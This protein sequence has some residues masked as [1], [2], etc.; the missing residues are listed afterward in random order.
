MPEDKVD[1]Q[2]NEAAALLREITA[3][4][5]DQDKREIERQRLELEDSKKTPPPKKWWA[6]AI[7]IL[8]LPAAVIAIVV[9]LTNASSTVQTT[10][11]TQAETEK[12]KVEEM[13]TRVELQKMLDE[14][15]ETKKKGVT[16]YRDEIEKTLPQLQ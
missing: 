12:I 8:A 14:L 13:K 15:A 9:Q 6:S 2:S 10:A 11:K 3:L 1:L 5:I 7:E 16:A 4:R